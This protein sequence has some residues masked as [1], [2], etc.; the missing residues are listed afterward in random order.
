MDLRETSD[1]I[2]QA[3]EGLAYAAGRD[4]IHR[5]VKP[6]NI[7]IDSSGRARVTDL[8]LAKLTVK[9]MAELTQEL[10]TVGTPNYMSPEQIRS[11]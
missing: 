6:S 10:Q 5:D 3:A 7:M 8:G 1:I 4:V 9:G 11:P 2:R